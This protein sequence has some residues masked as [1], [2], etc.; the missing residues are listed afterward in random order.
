MPE[1]S[2]DSIVR[3]DRENPAGAGQHP[4]PTERLYNGWYTR[5][6]ASDYRGNLVPG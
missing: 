3:L 6:S 5:S 4:M 1:T 2:P